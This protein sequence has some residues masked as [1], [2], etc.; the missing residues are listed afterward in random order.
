M[1][2]E[3][4]EYRS[5]RL[6]ALSLYPEYFCSDY[7]Q[8]NRIEKLHFERLIEIQ[9]E[10]GKIIGAFKSANLIGIC[11][12]SVENQFK[13]NAV[14]IVQMYVQSEF[15]GFGIGNGLIQA[16]IHVARELYS[17]DQIILEVMNNNDVAIKSYLA[18][19]FKANSSLES[20]DTTFYM[21]LEL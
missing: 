15:Q 7:D 10:Q 17:V 3:S 9:S 6:E 4:L 20:S 2:G 16:V 8:Q 14:E 5:I 12:L 13:S 11:G 18:S 21:S 19:G 1:A